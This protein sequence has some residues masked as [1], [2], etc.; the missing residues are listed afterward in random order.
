MGGRG[1]SS[2]SS[3]TGITYGEKIAAEAERLLNTWL[4]GENSNAP[5]NARYQLMEG[6]RVFANARIGDAIWSEYKTGKKNISQKEYD[7]YV[8]AKD[9]GDAV[10]DHYLSG[11]NAKNFSRKRYGL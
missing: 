7:A 2:A 5:N 4:S 1:Q 8:R 3:K 10:R 6:T 9:I 11:G